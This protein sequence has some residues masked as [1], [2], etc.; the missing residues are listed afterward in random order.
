MWGAAGI[1]GAM[2]PVTRLAQLLSDSTQKAKMTKTSLL[3]TSVDVNS[4]PCEFRVVG[5]SHLG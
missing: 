3:P 5:T 4:G 1:L 2:T